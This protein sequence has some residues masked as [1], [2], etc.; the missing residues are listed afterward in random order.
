MLRELTKENQG[1]KAKVDAAES[2]VM[3]FSQKLE[4]EKENSRQFRRQLEAKEEK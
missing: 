3:V 2:K 4:E 1:M